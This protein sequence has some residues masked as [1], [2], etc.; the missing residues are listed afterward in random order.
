[1]VRG[2][3]PES[4]VS[5][6]LG[7]PPIFEEPFIAVRTRSERQEQCR[8]Q[9]HSKPET[10]KRESQ[11]ECVEELEKPYGYREDDWNVEHDEGYDQPPIQPDSPALQFTRVFGHA[12]IDHQSA[13]LAAVAVLMSLKAAPKP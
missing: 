5:T 4:T 2:L 7:K 8:A 12:H 9:P 6:F 10:S 1:M 11:F 13:P 3:T